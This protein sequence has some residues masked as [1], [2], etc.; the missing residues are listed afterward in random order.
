[1][2]ATGQQR[3]HLAGVLA[4]SG[5]A[6]D[7]AAALGHRIAA[8][9]DALFDSHRD[10]GRLLS[11]QPRYQLGRGFATA[12]SAFGRRVRLNH[13]ERIAPLVQQLPAAGRR[14]GQN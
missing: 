4:T 5:L 14:A 6:Q 12:D 3:Q 7:L 8:N 9:N 11:S 10:V 2:L 1:V 13:V